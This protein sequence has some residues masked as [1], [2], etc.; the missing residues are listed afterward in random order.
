MARRSGRVRAVLRRVPLACLLLLIAGTLT[1][2]ARLY[3]R[4]VQESTRANV[5]ASSALPAAYG[6]EAPLPARF[7]AELTYTSLDA[8][9]SGEASTSVTWDDSWFTGD[10]HVYNHELARASSVLAAL[11]YSESGYYQ[12]GSNQPA[13]MEEALA[14][15]GFDEVCTDSYRFRSE[16]LDEVL[17]LVTDDADGVAYTIARKRLALSGGDGQ[18]GSPR[19]VILV[20]IRGSYG[21]EWLSNLDLATDETSDH[22][23]YC[24]AAREICGEVAAWADESAG[25]GAEVSV[26]LVGHSRG[27]AIANLA[28]AEIDDCR[29]GTVTSSVAGADSLAGIDRVYAYT[30]ASPATTLNAQAHDAR[31]ANIFNIANPSDIMPYLPLRTWGYERYGIDKALPAVDAEGFDELRTAMERLYEQSVGV[32]C[33]ADPSDKHVVDAVLTDVAQGIGSVGELVTPRGACAVF[34]SVAARVDPV[35]MLYS[36][37]PSTYI[38]WMNAIDED[39]LTESGAV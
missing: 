15:L 22:G 14:Q 33:G 27:G 18:E 20:S 31:Y 21:S 13:Y 3:T 26:L 2:S 4:R 25:D 11:A 28:A 1:A 29:A 17:N 19:D 34:A 12:S 37:Y 7:S 38:A 32:A 8:P 35:R 16:V 23:G 6:E 36:H 5:T 39:D 10:E 9:G 30:F 24:R